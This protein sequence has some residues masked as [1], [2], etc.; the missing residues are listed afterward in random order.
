MP[1]DK[2][3]S[4]YRYQQ[5]LQHHFWSRWLK[6]YLPRLTVRKWLEETP[7]LKKKDTVLISDDNLPR[8]KWLL[9]K[10]E[11]IFPGKDGLIRTVSVRTKKGII[12]RPVQR[13]HLLE[14]H[15][16]TLLSP[17]SNLPHQDP[18]VKKNDALPLVGEDVPVN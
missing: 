1:H 2:S 15:R 5:K 16:D 14:E 8:G 9:G 7:L 17:T 13:L 12:N 10:V 3:E 6:E 11:E 18:T 4:C